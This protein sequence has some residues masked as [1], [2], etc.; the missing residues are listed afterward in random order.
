[1][2]L[3]PL[4]DPPAV[5][6]EEGTLEEAIATLKSDIISWAS[7]VRRHPSQLLAREA[8]KK[9]TGSDTDS[10]EVDDEDNSDSGDA[11]NP[12]KELLL[13]LREGA[14]NGLLLVLI[15]IIKS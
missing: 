15:C 13:T 6:D 4:V 5:T 8:D 3:Q 11:K 2:F 12:K 14:D 1:M 9:P 7:D 10:T